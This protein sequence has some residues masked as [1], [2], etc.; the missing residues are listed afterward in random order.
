VPVAGNKFNPKRF[1]MR[2]HHLKRYLTKAEREGPWDILLKKGRDWVRIFQLGLKRI[3]YVKIIWPDD[4]GHDDTW[5]KTVD[6][7]HVWIEEL[8]S[9][10]KVPR[11]SG[12]VA[13]SEVLFRYAWK[14]RN[15]LCA[16]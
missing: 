12:M 11:L 6:G 4:W 5:I 9:P 10:G 15:Q 14:G 3:K 1:L 2:L 8:I 13:R 7:R 16:W